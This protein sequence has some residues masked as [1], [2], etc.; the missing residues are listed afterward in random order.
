MACH[1][2]PTQ[3]NSRCEQIQAAH[4][5]RSALATNPGPSTW[6]NEPPKPFVACD[7]SET[8]GKIPNIQKGTYHEPG[9]W[10]REELR[11]S[12]NLHRHHFVYLWEREREPLLL[13]LSNFER[14]AWIGTSDCLFT[15]LS[16]CAFAP[17]SQQASQLLLLGCCF[18]HVPPFVCAVNGQLY[19][20]LEQKQYKK[21]V[22]LC[23]Q[24]LQRQNWHQRLTMNL[25]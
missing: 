14:E 25:Q 13:S 15:Q 17:L 8:I 4:P 9:L 6:T 10:I 3:A 20:S 12:T 22:G 7:S 19:G 2:H 16:C 5:Q 18:I 11:Y 21:S 24:A 1:V 23:C